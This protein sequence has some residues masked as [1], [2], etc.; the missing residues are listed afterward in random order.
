MANVA[1]TMRPKGRQSGAG[2]QTQI[3]P[4]GTGVV[5]QEPSITLQDSE[6]TD[7]PTRVRQFLKKGVVKFQEVS[8]LQHMSLCSQNLQWHHTPL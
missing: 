3:S 5:W 8:Q 2:G 4:G 7:T 6:T 1:G